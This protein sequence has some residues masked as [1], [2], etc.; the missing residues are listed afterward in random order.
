MRC[1]ADPSPIWVPPIDGTVVQCAAHDG[2]VVPTVRPDG[3]TCRD[4]K[5]GTELQSH[6]GAAAVTR[7]AGRGWSCRT[8]VRPT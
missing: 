4:M 3:L 5:D 2:F 6:I 8:H 1:A 7:E